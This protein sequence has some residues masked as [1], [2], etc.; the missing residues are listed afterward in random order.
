MKYRIVKAIDVCGLN[1]LTPVVRLL[2]GEEPAK[3]LKDI[4]R[5]ILVPVAAFCV[6]LLVWGYLAPRHTTKYGAVPTPGQTWTAWNS[7]L[8]FHE[9]ETAK[10]A[11][12]VAT[13]GEREALLEFAATRLEELKPLAA[14][15]KQGVLDAREV[16]KTRKDKLIA[17]LQE[18][19]DKL[20]SA[21]T[22]GRKEKQAELAEMSEAIESEADR[23][24]LT[25]GYLALDA[26]MIEAKDAYNAVKKDIDAIRSKPDS[27]VAAALAL[28]T[29]Y[30]EE[31]QFLGKLQQYAGENSRQETVL[32]G[33]EKLAE[34]EEQFAA[35]TGSQ[36]LSLAKKQVSQI[37]RL[38]KDRE[39]TYAKPWTLPMQLVRSVFCVFVGFFI[40]VAIAVP[41]GVLC[42]LSKTFMAA[43]TPFIALF[44]P[45]SPIVWLLILWII[46]GG[47]FPDP[48]N[49]PFLDGVNSLINSFVWLVSFGVV[50]DLDINPAFIAS[51]LTVSMCS[52]WAT[53]TN[54]A[55]GVASVD[56]DHYNVARVLRLGFWDRL[57]KIVLPSALPLVFA[58]MRISLGVGWMVLIAAELLAS[59][60]GIGKFV[61]DM[62]QNGDSRSFAFIMA[63]VFVVGLIGL[64][65]DRIMIVLQRLVSFD[66]APAAV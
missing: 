63:M 13:D 42:G 33:E 49:S 25:E 66:G 14:E 60:E 54:T 51:A 5:F 58:G 10:E 9:R 36:A 37:R 29:K 50:K 53:M 12:V 64:I 44:K 57:F 18:E 11:A 6:F 40:G 26:W 17:P 38:E 55:L 3:Q 62:F 61:N 45:V 15:A 52:L 19:Y 8:T 48:N 1:F 56:P 31:V 24:A 21:Y 22:D 30:A 32:R 47:F 2:Y 39:K 16:E 23:E 46:V 59:S 28:D 34:Y 7:I 27:E 43:M 41:L 65:L 35:A 4:G 20:K